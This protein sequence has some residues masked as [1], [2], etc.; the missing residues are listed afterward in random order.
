MYIAGTFGRELKL[1]VWWSAFAATK[2]KSAKFTYSCTCIHMHG[3]PVP[4]HQIKIHQY[5][6]I[7]ILGPIAI[8]PNLIPANISGYTVVYYI[9]LP[10]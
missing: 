6:A 10:I 7:E 2:L 3:N 9:G 8:R 1:V 5:F 4:N